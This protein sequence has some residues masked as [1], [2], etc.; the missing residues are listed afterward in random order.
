MTVE[1]LAA[2]LKQRGLPHQIRSDGTL[3]WPISGRYSVHPIIFA[4]EQH[5]WVQGSIKFPLPPL[6]DAVD[7]IHEIAEY[8]TPET[9]ITLSLD[10][11]EIVLSGFANKDISD[12]MAHALSV[13][14]DRVLPLSTHLV[15]AGCW[16]SRLLALAF[17]PDDW[18]WGRIH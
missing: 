18:F 15:E 14:S 16:D 17:M 2:N 3:V 1:Y 8:L 5:G 9:V 10:S 12:E 13:L 4:D 11:R 6:P 7:L